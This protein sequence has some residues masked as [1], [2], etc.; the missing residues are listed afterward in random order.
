MYG[1]SFEF[2]NFQE[3]NLDFFAHLASS[4][5]HPNGEGYLTYG[6]LLGE[7]G[8]TS[9]K[10]G[11]AMWL[12]GRYGFGYKQHYKI[13]LEYNHGTKNWINLTQGSFD[14]Y[15]KLATR[16]NAYETYFM[17]VINRYAN[18]RLGYIYIDYDYSRSGW[19]VGKSE[20]I[21]TTSSNAETTV[22]SLQSLYM[23]MNVHF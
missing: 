16:G 14:I 22:K 10:D 9:I 6:G 5:A 23:K 21:N 15:N 20:A 4:V 8:D 12:G 13:G 18:L 2:T 19:F 7:K 11:Y 17:Y 3:S 1:A